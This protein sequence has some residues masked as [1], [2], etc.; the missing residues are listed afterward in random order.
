MD[1]LHDTLHALVYV[2]DVLIVD[3]SFITSDELWRQ[4]VVRNASS[5]ELTN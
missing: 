5:Y 1:T 3:L 2:L 4:T